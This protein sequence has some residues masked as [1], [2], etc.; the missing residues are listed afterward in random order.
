[1]VMAMEWINERVLK[2]VH[3]WPAP[4][5]EVTQEE[6]TRALLRAES[7]H[8]KAHMTVAPYEEGKVPLPEGA[9]DARYA[10][11]IGGAR[12]RDLLERHRRSPEE[13]DEPNQTFG[14]VIHWTRSPKCFISLFFVRKKSGALGMITDA[15]P[16]NRLCR[17][18][19]GVQLC[20]AE[21]LGRN[22]LEGGVERAYMA[23]ADVAD[24]FHRLRMRE[25]LPEFF[26]LPPL[27]ARAAGLERR[28]DVAVGSPAELWWPCCATF[29]MG[30]SW[31]LIVAQPPM[32]DPRGPAVLG[33]DALPAHCVYVDN[34]GVL[35][36]DPRRRVAVFVGACSS[37]EGAGL[38]LRDLLEGVGAMERLASRPPA[39]GGWTPGYAGCWLGG[40]D[41][42]EFGFGSCSTWWGGR[43]A[44]RHGRVPERSRC[45]L[46]SAAA[47]D[48]ALLQ[49]GL[50]SFDDEIDDL[51]RECFEEV[52]DFP[53]MP[54]GLLR[55]ADWRV[56]IGG[57]WRRPEHI[58]LLETRAAV[59]MLRRW[60]RARPGAGARKLYIG[61]NLGMVFS[62]ER[63]SKLV[64]G[65]G[66][67]PRAGRPAPGGPKGRQR[68]LTEADVH[69]SLNSRLRFKL[70]KPP[71]DLDEV[72][73]A[74]EEGR[75]TDGSSGATS[76]VPV[77]C[78]PTRT[79]RLARYAN[80]D[81]K[82]GATHLEQKSATPRVMDDNK[83]RMRLALSFAQ[84]RRFQA[85]SQT[86]V[87][88][89]Y[90][91]KLLAG[92]MD[93]YPEYGKYGKFKLPRAG[94]WVIVACGFY[95]RPCECLGI[96]A[97]DLVAPVTGVSS[98]WGLLVA[99]EERGVATKV[100]A[101]DDNL[102]WDAPC[103]SFMN[104]VFQ[105][106]RSRPEGQ[107]LCALDYP[108]VLKAFKR[109]FKLI[110][111]DAVPYHMRHSGP[112]WKRL[113]EMGALQQ[114]QKRGRWA[115][116]K[117][118]VRHEKHGRL[119][120]QMAEHSAAKQRWLLACERRVGECVL[121]SRVAD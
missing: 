13:I 98:H 37:C 19:P 1:M 80:L 20:T 118:L 115:S 103:L 111:A 2:A 32:A 55:K 9:R 86:D 94:L 105:V 3:S 114:I 11:A 69:A 6:A 10:D 58:T 106:L 30:F 75:E 45:R 39:T 109:A 96:Q 89:S 97:E 76:G 52:G 60:A 87:H 22:E 73:G 33:P 83:R 40:S 21:G 72:G 8:D 43:A 82:R 44:A 61:D 100:G 15:R 77:H 117:S 67:Q 47:R 18:P 46:G 24:C 88:S 7:V 92:W 59:A 120:M 28:S 49:S 85:R 42:S 34:L 91:V 16:T 66:R 31:G 38:A 4:E 110:G 23:Q 78:G 81:P 90:G 70:A 56:I 99:P 121:G 104:D 17:P 29:P 95:F 62:L 93:V 84:R 63:M 26:A 25:E 5:R 101:F 71:V 50:G 35:D 112:S 65:A 119:A 14:G 74:S 68:T 41:A 64:L 79:R 12:A 48:H 108:R 36:A 54:P 102:L 27:A 107:P 57:R 116:V 53:E 113:K 51:P